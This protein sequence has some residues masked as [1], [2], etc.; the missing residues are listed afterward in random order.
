[1]DERNACSSTMD[2]HEKTVKEGKSLEIPVSWINTLTR[3]VI[4]HEGR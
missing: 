2:H 4:S 1:M 3:E